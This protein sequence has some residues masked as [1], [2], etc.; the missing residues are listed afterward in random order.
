MHGNGI[1]TY[2]DGRKYEGGYFQDKKQGRGI[3]T[4]PDGKK[5]NG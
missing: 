2:K 4:W 1:Y 3:Y 5:F